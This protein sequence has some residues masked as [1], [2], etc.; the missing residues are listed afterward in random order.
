MIKTIKTAA[1][2]TMLL[3]A[4]AAYAGNATVNGSSASD[5]STTSNAIYQMLSGG[6]AQALYTVLVS[7]RGSTTDPTTGAVTSPTVFIDGVGEATITVSL[8]GEV[9]VTP[10]RRRAGS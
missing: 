9:T 1:A 3:G 4:T 6:N 10:V 7:M 2:A 8:D 5:A